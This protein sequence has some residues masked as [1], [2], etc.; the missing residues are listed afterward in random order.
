MC[1]GYLGSFATGRNQVF[2][3]SA[4]PQRR[5]FFSK[6]LLLPIGIHLI[7]LFMYVVPVA[8][9]L[10]KTWYSQAFWNPVTLET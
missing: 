3:R 5:I 1:V 10:L 4:V 9:V 7:L 6:M 8:V 2:D